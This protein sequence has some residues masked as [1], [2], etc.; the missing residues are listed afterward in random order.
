MFKNNKEVSGAL[1][2]NSHFIIKDWFFNQNK[3]QFE[4]LGKSFFVEKETDKAF[5]LKNDIDEKAFKMW[6][7]KS[8][9]VSIKYVGIMKIENF[10]IAEEE[11]WNIK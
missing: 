5:L 3:K 6:V 1:K 4:N 8:Q 7:P 10:V 11:K 9:V 2:S